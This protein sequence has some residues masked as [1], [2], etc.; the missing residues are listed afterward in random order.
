MGPVQP[1]QMNIYQ[2]NTYRNGLSWLHFGNE[3]RVQES[4]HVNQVL[5]AKFLGRDGLLCFSSICKFGSFKNLF[6][7]IMS[8]SEHYF[9]FRRFIML[10]QMKKLISM[11]YGSSAS[12][13]KPW[14]WMKFDLILTMRDLYI[15]SNLNPLTKLTSSSRSTR[16]KDI[17]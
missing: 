16:L 13:W 11:S 15:N 12:C 9:T 7:K 2:S 6:V 17:T 8:L 4:Q 3:S 10:V 1:I 5:R 14:R